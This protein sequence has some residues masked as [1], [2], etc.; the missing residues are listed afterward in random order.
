MIKIAIGM[1]ALAISVLGVILTY[2]WR[3]NTKAMRILLEGQREIASIVREVHEGQ[4][5]IA[6]ILA[7]R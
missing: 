2:I 3:A 1:V 7:E 6:R 5:E 4:K